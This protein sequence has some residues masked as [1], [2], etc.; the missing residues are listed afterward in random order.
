MAKI[1]KPFKMYDFSNTKIFERTKK[2]GNHTYYIHRT[3]GLRYRESED[4]S[5]QEVFQPHGFWCELVELKNVKSPKQSLK[6]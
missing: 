1:L 2:E 6:G 5:L 4:S 3:T